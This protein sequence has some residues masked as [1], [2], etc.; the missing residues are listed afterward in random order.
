MLLLRPTLAV[1]QQVQAQ[2]GEN[3]SLGPRKSRENNCLS[4]PLTVAS[5]L[6]GAL[7]DALALP[8][9]SGG[10]PSPELLSPFWFSSALIAWSLQNRAA[11]D[12]QILFK[13]A[14]AS[15][16]VMP[17]AWRSASNSSH[18]R[19]LLLGGGGDGDDEYGFS[20]SEAGRSE[21]EDTAEL[22]LR[23]TNAIAIVIKVELCAEGEV[24]AERHF[25]AEPCSDTLFRV[26]E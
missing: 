3:G 20:A 9:P 5:S 23:V 24:R 4:L 19:L 21:P 26:R 8:L 2:S 1:R 6:T 11:P 12:A 14:A 15:S 7:V 25:T 22:C 10:R 17:L 18:S 16:C 13:N